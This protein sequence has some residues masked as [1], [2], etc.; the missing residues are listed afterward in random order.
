MKIPALA[1]TGGIGSG[2]SKVL[3][4]L[5][6]QGFTVI[7]ADKLV[8]ELYH[9]SSP[10]YEPYAQRLDAWLGT[11]FAQ[12]SQINKKELRH[13]LNET[14]NGFEKIMLLAKPF[15]E[16]L[17]FEKSLEYSDRKL[18][19]EVPLLVEAGMHQSFSHVMVVVCDKEIRMQRIAQR[20]P[21]L[22]VSEIEKLI[23]VQS[24]DSDKIKIADYV[25]N[26]SGTEEMLQSQVSQAC[27]ELE[28]LAHAKRHKP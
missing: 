14:V 20:N 18:V 5:Q 21:D 8:A 3:S 10:Y 16:Q 15:V 26:N 17:M 1:V 7:D 25:I 2:K 11:H 13:I 19:F 9:A 12:D 4:L 23:N 24:P 28:S 22:S 27:H 6:E